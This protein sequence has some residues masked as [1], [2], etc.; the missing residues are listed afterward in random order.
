MVDP[1][2]TSTLDFV[3]FATTGLFTGAALGISLVEHPT[4]L[5]LPPQKS[6][7]VF[8]ISFPKAATMQSSL[9]LTSCIANAS[10]G[11]MTEGFESRVHFI[12]AGVML[13]IAAF[14]RLA[15]MPINWKLMGD[16][17]LN[18]NTITS[19]MKSWSQL[20]W[21]R[22]LASMAAFASL[23]YLKVWRK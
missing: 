8:K 3:S 4:K 5:E 14:T 9:A 2:L 16:Q 19:M 22:S 18:D 21:V 23:I 17:T 13:G 7:E 15:L 11:L 10:V 12:V 1:R 20:H 6:R